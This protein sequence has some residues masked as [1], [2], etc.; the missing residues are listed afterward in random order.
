M[1]SLWILLMLLT[2]FGAIAFGWLMWTARFTWQDRRLTQ[3]YWLLAIA[4][5][6]ATMAIA[7]YKL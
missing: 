3:R 6:F 7:W 1:P 2:L 5:T 4:C